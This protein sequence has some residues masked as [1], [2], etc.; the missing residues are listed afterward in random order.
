MKSTNTKWNKTTHD[1]GL[2][3]K[4]EKKLFVFEYYGDVPIKTAKGSC[5]CQATLVKGNKV[6]AEV[7][8]KKSS[9][10]VSKRVTVIFEDDTRDL[11][12]LKA[13]VR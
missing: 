10:S 5:S 7:T 11:L 4:G 3:N 2:V 13:K 1:F 6:Q 8:F 9:L 12:T